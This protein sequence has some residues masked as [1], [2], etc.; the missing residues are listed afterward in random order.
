M[1]CKGSSKLRMATRRR[2]CSRRVAA[3]WR[4]R[5]GNS[6]VNFRVGFRGGSGASAHLATP[7]SQQASAGA[8]VQ[9]ST[10]LTAR[11]DYLFVRGIHLART[12]NVNLLP[13]V[14]LT[15]AN[16]ASLGVANPAP[17][18]IGRPVFSSG[19][20]NPQLGDI[21]ELEDSA[22]STYNGLSLTLNRRMFDELEF[23]ASYTLSKALDN[24]SDFDEQPQNPFDFGAE[25]GFSRQ[26][27]R[28][29][30]VFNGLWE[31]PIG[32]D[33]D[34]PQKKAGPQAGRCACSGISSWRPSSRW[35]AGGWRIL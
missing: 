3:R 23:S 18:Q 22:S 15:A 16:A 6:A 32:D 4:L 17:Q 26:D 25:R 27:Q 9:L 34:S 31:L 5:G 13:P 14:T 35:A 28:H 2:L 8:E 29:L 24:A 7:Y 30:L 12:V 10:N 21:Y 1:A 19:R 33:E 11:A 20:R